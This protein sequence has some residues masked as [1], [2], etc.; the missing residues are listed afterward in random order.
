[1]VGSLLYAA[2]T[3]RPDIAQAVLCQSYTK[4][5]NRAKQI[6]RYLRATAYLGLSYK[7]CAIGNL[8]SYSDA[9][10]AGDMDMTV[11]PL[12]ETCSHLRVEQ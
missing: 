4:S 1:M 12:Q 10:W 11:I 9:D 3:T 7:K 6:L 8:I 2:I 5:F